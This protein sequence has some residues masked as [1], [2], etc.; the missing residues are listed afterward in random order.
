MLLRVPE[1]S[2]LPGLVLFEF[3]A[4]RPVRTWPRRHPTSH[5]FVS[6]RQEGS[7]GEGR[8]GGLTHSRA[9]TELDFPGFFFCGCFLRHD[10]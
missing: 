7:E 2:F 10:I 5:S 3:F 8:G 9:S 1:A 6:K 4:S